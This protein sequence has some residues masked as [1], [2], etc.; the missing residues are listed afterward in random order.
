MAKHYTVDIEPKIT[1]ERIILL[2]TQHVYRPS[3]SVLVDMIRLDGSSTMS[4]LGGG[5]S[6][7]T[8]TLKKFHSL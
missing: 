4:V 8:T 2:D 3:I 1:S 6:L 5:E 7:T